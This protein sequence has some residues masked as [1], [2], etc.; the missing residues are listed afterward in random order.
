MYTAILIM[1]CGIGVGRLLASHI[2]ARILGRIIFATIVFLLFSLGLQ[3]GANDILFANL[4]ELGL[5][6]VLL[7]LACVAGS[8]LAVRLAGRVAGKRDLSGKRDAR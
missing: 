2:D 5:Q 1:V 6:A 3:I 7:M 8:I 4:P